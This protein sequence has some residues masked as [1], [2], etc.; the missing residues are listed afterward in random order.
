MK[1]L[2]MNERINLLIILLFLTYSTFGQELIPVGT[3]RS[4][5]NYEQ[6]YLVEKTTTKVFSTTDQGL[7]YFDQED[8]SVNKLSKVDG[9]SDVGISA[10][11][12]NAE[13]EYLTLGYQNGNVDI[14]TSDGIQNLPVLLESDI[15]ESKRVN[16]VSFYNGNMNLSTNFGLLVLTTDNQVTEAYQNLGENGEIIE[17]RSSTILND[18]MYL[19]TEDGVLA[20]ELT[21]GDNLQDFNNWE[22]FP[23]SVVYDKDMVAIAS[24]NSSVY[25]TSSSQLFKLT[26]SA[27]TEIDLNLGTEESIINI[28]MG[29]NVLL[30][31]TDQ[32]AL[33]MTASASIEKINIPD[34]AEVNDLLQEGDENFWYADG[35][36]GLSKIENDAVEHIVLSGPLNGIEKLKIESEE[37]YALPSL[38]TNYS[39]PVSNN[40]GYSLFSNGVWKTVKPSDINEFSNISD[41][42]SVGDGLLLSSFGQGILDDETDGIIDYTNSPLDENDASTGNTLVSGLALDQS[43]NIW[44]ANFSAHSLLKW[45]GEEEWESFDFG[46]SAGSEPTSLSVNENN[47]VWM[48]LGLVSGRGL[49]AYDIAADASRY[50]TATATNLPSNQVNDVAFGK[51]DEIWFATD[52]GIAYFPFSFGVVTDQTIDVSLP[53]FEQS[54][55]FQDKQVN[56]IAIDGGN[57]MWVGTLEGLWLFDDGFNNLIHHFTEN[58]SPL[59][60]NSVIDLA[61]HPETGELFIATEEGIVSYR[62]KA[63]EGTNVHHQVKIFP[64]PVLPDFEG[65]VGLSGLANDVRI[66]ITTIAGQLV[67]EV[68]AVGG[69]A[70]WDVR[71]YAGRRVSTGVY[72]VFSADQEGKETFVGKIAVID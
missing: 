70:S 60:S 34:N 54:I 31:L 37:V 10:L 26:G 20:G 48:T 44:V 25:S 53:I 40:L 51:D 18:V 16:H 2:R 41:V 39:N 63:T 61:I 43:D 68:N 58:N 57:R 5:F 33:T 67:R 19:A 38:A 72:L 8:G 47:Q 52:L 14:I 71:D 21:S 6:T 27:W 4:H 32:R 42:V 12:Y 36:L 28:R 15:T 62:T 22:R 55:L 17:I 11:T 46:T 7:M 9:L 64:N 66:K 56:T 65:W 29:L 30:I 45:D 24:A 49:L 59:P 69:G 3:W 35:S 50:V 13:S 1:I 23:T